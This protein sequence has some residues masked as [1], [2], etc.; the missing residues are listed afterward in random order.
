[1]DKD[2]YRKRVDQGIENRFGYLKEK[3]NEELGMMEEAI[4]N[5]IEYLLHILDSKDASS[6]QKSEIR[7]SDLKFERERLDYIEH[8]LDERKD[9]RSIRR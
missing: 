8:I 2:E 3:T 9:K 6:D 5:E 4:S 1:M 7:N